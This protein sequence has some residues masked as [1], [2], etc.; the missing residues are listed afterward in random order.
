MPFDQYPAMIHS[1]GVNEESGNI[2]G[3]VDPGSLRTGRSRN[4]KRFKNAAEL[5]EDVSSIGGVTVRRCAEVAGSLSEVVQAEELIERR[6]GKVHCQEITSH[7]FE[8]VCSSCS[9]NE[10]AVGLE[11]VI[12]ENVIDADDLGLGR[13]RDVLVCKDPGG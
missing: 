3:I 7:V 2:S 4:V 13:T 1:F 6:A 11:N 12:H 8:T 9:V 10:K 5:V